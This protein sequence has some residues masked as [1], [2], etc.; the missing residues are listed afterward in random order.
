M[1]GPFKAGHLNYL[2]G[3]TRPGA[4]LPVPLIDLL[5]PLRRLPCGQAIRAKLR[6][7]AG[8]TDK[9]TV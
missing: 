9:E 4:D 3:V 2:Q 5:P 7:H 6:R 8:R 1:V